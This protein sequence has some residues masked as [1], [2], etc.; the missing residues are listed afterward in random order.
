MFKKWYWHRQN[1]FQEI[2][3]KLKVH[4][5]KKFV[6]LLRRETLHQLFIKIWGNI[7]R[8]NHCICLRNHQVSTTNFTLQGFFL[9]TL[10]IMFHVN[11]YNILMFSCL[12]FYTRILY[13]HY[14]CS[15]T[16]INSTTESGRLKSRITG[17]NGVSMLSLTGAWLRISVTTELISDSSFQNPLDQ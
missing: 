11:H 10:L 12:L 1:N 9:Y 3:I 14:K 4:E 13:D 7:L 17:K 15:H 2:K 5:I 16:S 8:K 6:F